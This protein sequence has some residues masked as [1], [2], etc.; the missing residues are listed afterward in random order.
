MSAVEKSDSKAHVRTSYMDA[1]VQAQIENSSA[2][3]A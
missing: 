3:S 1:L 2:M